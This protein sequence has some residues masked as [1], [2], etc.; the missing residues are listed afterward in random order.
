MT[1]K[2]FCEW[3]AREIF[4][5]NWEFNKESFEEIACRKLV[6]L[7]IVE[8]IDDEYRLKAESEDKI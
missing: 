8:L 6:K 2:D 5:E 4:S 7:G 3:I 1:Y